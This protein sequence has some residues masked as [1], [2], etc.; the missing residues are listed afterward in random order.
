[1][2]MLYFVKLI[3]FVCGCA[4]IVWLCHTGAD[5]VVDGTDEAKAW[6]GGLALGNFKITLFNVSFLLKVGLMLELVIDYFELSVLL[7]C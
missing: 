6:R 4:I 7:S 3:L 1:M 5:V 2:C